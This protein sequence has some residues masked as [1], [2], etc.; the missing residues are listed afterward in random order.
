MAARTGRGRATGLCYLNSNVY[1]LSGWDWKIKFTKQCKKE[2]GE[3][4]LGRG[5]GCD[6]SG[7]DHNLVLPGSRYNCRCAVD[8][9]PEGLLGSPE[10]AQCMRDAARQTL[11]RGSV[12]TTPRHP[13]RDRKNPMA[14]MLT[15]S[16]WLRFHTI[17]TTGCI[18]L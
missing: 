8:L 7:H 2:N 18:P 14:S 5:Q 6:V 13:I 10:K 16:A 12:H 15:G 9:A 4:L 1:V 3:L 11:R 17:P